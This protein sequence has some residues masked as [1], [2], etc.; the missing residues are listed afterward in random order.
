M[1][2]WRIQKTGLSINVT[3]GRSDS[4]I[5]SVEVSARVYGLNKGDS[6]TI[7]NG[8]SQLNATVCRRI[9]LA[10]YFHATQELEFEEQEKV[11]YR[12]LSLYLNRFIRLISIA[13]SRRDFLAGLFNG[14]EVTWKIPEF[15]TFLEIASSSGAR[16]FISR[17][18]ASAGLLT[19]DFSPECERLVRKTKGSQAIFVVNSHIS[20]TGVFRNS[21]PM[22]DFPSFFQINAEP[23]TE[24]RSIT[25]NVLIEYECCVSGNVNFNLQLTNVYL[26]HLGYL[27][28]HS[29]DVLNID[30]LPDS[31]KV[32]FISYS[33][34]SEGKKPL[35][36]I[37]KGIVTYAH[38]SSFIHLST[39]WAHF[40]EDNVPALL[41][42][43]SEYPK[44]EIFYLGN[45]SES[46]KELILN[47]LPE[48]SCS[49]LTPGYSYYF[50]DLIVSLHR[51]SRN[52][53]I[54][55]VTSSIPIIDK[56]YMAEIRKRI[57]NHTESNHAPE[58]RLFITRGQQG[59]RKMSNLY[60]IEKYFRSQGF[61][62]V[63]SENLDFFQR[64]N[65]FRS[66]S[67][68]VGE[69]GAG[70]VNCYFAPEGINVIELRHPSMKNS[71]EFKGLA[72]ITNQHYY[73]VLGRPAGLLG[74]LR[75]GVDSHHVKKTKVNELL[76]KLGLV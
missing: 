3:P 65:L 26:S 74:K 56:D 29:G 30:D 43:Y 52:L 21:K 24:V 37:G 14:Y 53:S 48:V 44:R 62:V 10:N 73:I 49:E 71:I 20:G 23:E 15:G 69:S 35:L 39:N 1:K 72:S 11:G 70:L 61:K 25:D 16:V 18:A 76:V 58:S 19:S 33:Q 9:F 51:D 36:S 40:I 45:L 7:T 47:L 27:I 68:I 4:E 22:F 46:Q 8:V 17:Q 75:F 55:G 12:K 60:S 42:L 66:A 54:Q 28:N 32:S 57:L 13:A 38:P 67:V 2:R 63:K 59:F 34:F 64:I 50:N 41:K 31:R 6:L 5:D